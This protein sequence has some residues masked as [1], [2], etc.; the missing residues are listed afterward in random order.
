MPYLVSLDGFRMVRG[1][2]ENWY[3]VAAVFLGLSRSATAKFRN[4]NKIFLTKSG[5][6][7]FHE[8]LFQQYL[9]DSGFTYT[10]VNG[11]TLITTDTGIK[12]FLPPDYS[13]VIDEIYVRKEY[14]KPT[15]QGR[16]VIDI[17]SSIADSALY[18]ASLGAK[19]VYSFE[20]DSTRLELAKE[21][22][23]L[24][25][26]SAVIETFDRKAT[27]KEISSLIE[28]TSL[29]DVFMKIDCEGCEYELI[30]NLSDTIFS[31]VKNIVLEYHDGAS[32]IMKKLKSV[33]YNVRHESRFLI[34]EGKIFANK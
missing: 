28:R 21:N 31:R 25:G 27:S 32:S 18:F 8:A 6:H 14:G 11:R 23:Q 26:M 1:Y 4:G 33:G 19:K 17:G 10:I 3:S 7:E 2:V 13:N 30:E 9:K 24:N 20:V 15:V 12:L 22:V 5:F 29:Y 16:I 34:K